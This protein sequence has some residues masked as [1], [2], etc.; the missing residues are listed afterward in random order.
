VLR[1]VLAGQFETPRRVDRS[2]DP[3]L[4]AICLKAMSPEP[5]GRYSSARALADDIERWMADEPV[6]ARRDP[7]VARAARWVRRH[8][9]LA[10]AVVVSLTVAAVASGVGAMLINVQRADAVA[11]RRRAE[12]NLARARQ[13]VDE[14]YTR[15]AG[16]LDDIPRMDDYQRTVL[17]NAGAFYER[18]A[19]PQSS[20]PATRLAAAGTQLRLAD[21]RWKLGRLAEARA[22]ARRALELY[23][24]L[25]REAPGEPDRRLGSA[26]A[27]ATL[28]QIALD[29][30]DFGG[31]AEQHQRSIALREG[32]IADFPSVL[33]YRLDLGVAWRSLGDALLQNHR[34]D[35]ADSAYREAMVRLE[36]LA[37]EHP[38]DQEVRVALAD[39]LDDVANLE[40]QR[41]RDAESERLR[42]RALELRRSALETHPRDLGARCRVAWG[43]N[44]LGY[45]L[46]RLGRVSEADP[47]LR[48]AIARC[49]RIHDEHPDIPANRI[50][51]SLAL[52]HRGDLLLP[53]A[54][55]E[56]VLCY[57]RAIEALRSDSTDT[58]ESSETR[59]RLAP[60]LYALARAEQEHG[61]IDE[62]DGHVR[63]AIRACELALQEHVNDRS[64]RD[65]QGQ[66][67]LLLGLIARDRG[68][69]EDAVACS[70]RAA[71]FH[72]S[73]LREIPGDPQIR[74]SF[75][76][77]L[78][79]GLG[80]TLRQMGQV[81]EALSS[82]RRAAD[83]LAAMEH[84][85]PT[86]LYNLACSLAQCS[87]LG[88]LA[89]SSIPASKAAEDA[90]RA[91]E[92]FRRA[93]DSGT[94]TYEGVRDDTDL[95]PLRGR[96]DF[97]ALVMDL[98]F[99]ADPFAR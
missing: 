75:I 7:L 63:E 34:L 78:T 89:E 17:E 93:V 91:V 44:N 14:M 35:E 87:A 80:K 30:R 3:G 57:R 22:A 11:Q 26:A 72:E 43:L 95:D 45:T 2:T 62:A 60:L 81:R 85:D 20:D 51:L 42:R 40:T 92:A 41:N 84:M 88:P 73:L 55:A 50:E 48:E 16:E 66:A 98:A 19:L 39:T 6:I 54:L 18:E 77:D 64:F 21:I 90:D 83:L 99:P 70:R 74:G 59:D 15:V 49:E 58:A 53:V 52:S 8:R 94:C 61:S 86:D 46:V 79:E 24:E 5:A 31:A 33:R 38:G 29:A 71:E 9:T 37:G 23:E 68:R 97:R 28:G 32:L 1:L 76:A 56:A 82:Y 96:A 12:T 25:T 36:P 4:E 67:W 10:A 13:V 65:L 47:V 69:T 27:R